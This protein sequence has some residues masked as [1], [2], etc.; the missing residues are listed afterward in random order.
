[1]VW[2]LTLVRHLHLIG[3]WLR[4]DVRIKPN[5]TMYLN[6]D[7]TTRSKNINHSRLGR[8]HDWE[9]ICIQVQDSTN[10]QFQ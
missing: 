1:M 10:M 2:L 6:R 4:L 9:D 5:K 8:Q 3:V 7:W